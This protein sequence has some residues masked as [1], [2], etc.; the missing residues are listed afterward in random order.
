M[1]YVY[2]AIISAEDGKFLV[3]V[4]DLPGLHTFGNSMADALYMAQDAIEMWLWDAENN[5][6]A[7]PQA[8]DT[9]KITKMCKSK[10]QV[11]SL[12]AADTDEYRRQNDTRSIKKTLS[13][14]SWL[15]HKAEMANAPFSQILQQGLKDYLHIAQ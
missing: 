15:N 7:I 8:S 2:P 6:E 1:K 5:G 13:I 3:S 10:D 4:P 12:V 14:P 9:Q 11:V